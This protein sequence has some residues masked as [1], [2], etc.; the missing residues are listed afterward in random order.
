METRNG[1]HIPPEIFEELVERLK[2]R[3]HELAEEIN[4][5]GGEIRQEVSANF[6]EALPLREDLDVIEKEDEIEE[7]EIHLIESAL[8]RVSD[9][10]YGLCLECGKPIPV[11]R[12]LYLPHARYC[13][14]CQ[15]KT[16]KRSRKK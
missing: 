7:D 12:L 6:K 11:E 15:E 3:H 5:L 4:T 2:R 16:E 14:P 9:K 8:Q 13:V 1:K 10:E